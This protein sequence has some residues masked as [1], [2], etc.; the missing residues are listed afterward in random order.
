[1]AW[2]GILSGFDAI[3]IRHVRFGTG[4]QEQM[5]LTHTIGSEV[6]AEN[7]LP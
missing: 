4:L 3:G 6:Y 2:I 5:A 7:L 1:V